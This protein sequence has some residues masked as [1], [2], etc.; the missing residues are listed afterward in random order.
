[1]REYVYALHDFLPKHVDEVLP[2]P[3]PSLP[4]YHVKQ[5]TE[6]HCT[7]PCPRPH[8]ANSFLQRDDFKSLSTLISLTSHTLQTDLSEF[9]PTVPILSFTLSPAPLSREALEEL[10]SIL[11]ACLVPSRV[12]GP[13]PSS[14]YPQSP[15][16]WSFKYSL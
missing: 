9:L 6:C 7:A 16:S 4:S 11:I 1:M 8:L 10:L 5:K 12:L 13:S 2:E 14:S 3:D 15:S